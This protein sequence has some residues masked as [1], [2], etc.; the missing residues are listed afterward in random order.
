[1]PQHQIT[2]LITISKTSIYR[3][4]KKAIE[5]GYNPV[6]SK[7]LLDIYVVN[8]PKPGRP[9][10][11]SADIVQMVKDIVTKNSTTRAWSCGAI[12][13][14]VAT[15]LNVKKSIYAKS[16]YKILKA[17]KYKSCK[18]TTKPGLIDEIKRKR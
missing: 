5:Q 8:D 2:A 15:R 10:V 13:T 4:R 3:I 17:K 11:L 6:V 18:Q 7:L 14:E 12:A 9:S 1:M 16:V